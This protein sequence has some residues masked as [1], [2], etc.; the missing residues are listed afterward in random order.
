MLPQGS[1]LWHILQLQKTTSENAAAGELRFTKLA[2]AK[3]SGWYDT[4]DVK[5]PN[6]TPKDLQKMFGN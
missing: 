2:P 5:F 3:G 1:A 4:L 6:T